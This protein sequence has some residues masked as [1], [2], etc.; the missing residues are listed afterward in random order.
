MQQG[1]PATLARQYFFTLLNAKQN[2]AQNRAS[3]RSFYC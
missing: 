2:R 3:D 1:W